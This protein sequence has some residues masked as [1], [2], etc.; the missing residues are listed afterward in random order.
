MREDNYEG[1]AHLKPVVSNPNLN[2][3]LKKNKKLSI[4][5]FGE[6]VFERGSVFLL[7]KAENSIEELL[8]SGADAVRKALKAKVREVSIFFCSCLTSQEVAYFLQGFQLR[9]YSWEWKSQT[10]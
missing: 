3:K 5:G 4:Y 10:D 7:K 8:Q 9:N 2:E 6:T 1:N